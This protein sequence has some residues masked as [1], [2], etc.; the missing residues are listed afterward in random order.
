MVGI[1][2]LITKLKILRACNVTAGESRCVQATDR[3]SS[4]YKSVLLLSR[5]RC[6]A[7]ACAIAAESAGRV[8]MPPRCCSHPVMKIL[9]IVASLDE[10][11]K[12]DDLQPA[13]LLR[14]RSVSSA[15]AACCWCW[16]VTYCCWPDLFGVATVKMLTSVTP[17]R[18]SKQ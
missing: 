11:T 4:I 13:A 2:T 7:E 15:P 10:G 8:P 12:R 3:L 1:S 6:S 17:E 16:A 9:A 5:S 14:H 18:P